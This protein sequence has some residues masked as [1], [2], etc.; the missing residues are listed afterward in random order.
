MISHNKWGGGGFL[1]SAG[2]I[3]R[4]G[5]AMLSDTLLS[6]ETIAALTTSQRTSDGLPTGYGMGFACDTTESGIPYFGHNGGSVGGKSSLV[7]YPEQ[8]TVLAIV[9]NDTRAS[10]PRRHE[11]AE[12]F[13]GIKQPESGL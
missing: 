5:N 11:L 4:F 1:S 13:M 2:D 9:C 10:F 3:I 7:I 6:R 12:M 8:K